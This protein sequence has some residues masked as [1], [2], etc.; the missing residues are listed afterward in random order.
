MIEPETRAVN[1]DRPPSAPGASAN[2]LLVPLQ[3]RKI[4]RKTSRGREAEVAAT[5]TAE[6]ERLRAYE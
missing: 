4:K 2:N 1:P 6:A 5:L 3:V